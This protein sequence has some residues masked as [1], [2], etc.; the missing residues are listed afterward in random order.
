M[1]KKFTTYPKVFVETLDY[2]GDSKMIVRLYTKL[3]LFHIGNWY[4]QKF[5]QSYSGKSPL[6]IIE[7]TNRLHMDVYHSLH[8]AQVDLK[9]KDV[10]GDPLWELCEDQTDESERLLKQLKFYQP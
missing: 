9:A 10:Y 6:D 3:R 7:A 8:F 4:Y 1:D 2:G 5:Y